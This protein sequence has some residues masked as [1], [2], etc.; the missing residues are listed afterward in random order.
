MLPKTIVITGTTS[1]IGT[2]TALALARQGHTLY[3][4]VR[5]VEKGEQVKNDIITETKNDKIYVIA[6]DLADLQSVRR[7]ADELKAKL[8]N[9]QVL[10]NNAG[11]IVPK[12]EVSKDGFELTFAFN[13]LG[14]FLLTMSLMTLL[15]KGQAR[16][17]NVSS[18][19]HKSAKVNFDDLQLEK[20][21]SSITAYGNAK[22]FNIYFARSIAER[23]ANKGVTAY[24]L[25][26][27]VVNTGFGSQYTGFLKIVLSLIRPF[28]ISP[29][30]GAETSVFLATAPQIEPLSGKYFKNKKEAKPSVAS[31]DNEARQQLWLTSEELVKPYML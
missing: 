11:G 29:E 30:K 2:Q 22:L 27:G 21:Y 1:G 9:I 16:V 5:N 13:H 12:R 26:P 20:D 17:I 8:V 18:E 7:A 23:Y 25:H 10:I 6:C 4:L 15:E 31:Y 14:H 28:M 19:A 24:S 3:M